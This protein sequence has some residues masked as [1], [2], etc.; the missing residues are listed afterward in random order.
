MK[1]TP[2]EKKILALIEKN[3]EIITDTK[4]RTVIAKE[5]DNN[6]KFLL[7][8]KYSKNI[9]EIHLH[10]YITNMI[11]IISTLR[12]SQID[13]PNSYYSDNQSEKNKELII[14]IDINW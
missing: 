7:D 5:N 8:Q 2:H 11:K 9:I 4:K 3:P 10:L 14:G 1:L 12:T 13:N 6:T